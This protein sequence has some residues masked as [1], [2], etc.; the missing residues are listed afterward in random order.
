MKYLNKKI[1]LFNLLF[2]FLIIIINF[3]SLTEN[4]INY[5]TFKT[6]NYQFKDLLSVSITVLTI[7]LGFMA[8]IA[9]VL[10]SMCDKRIMK[11]ISKFDKMETVAKSIKKSIKYG[12]LCLV[13]LGLMYTNLDG[14]ISYLITSVL[15]DNINHNLE[16]L[17]Y[18][19][20]IFSPTGIRIITLYIT[21]IFLVI[22][23]DA[24]SYLVFLI[25][26]IAEETFSNT[27]V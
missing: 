8:T 23:I 7:F 20:I 6:N 21:I 22:F 27:N 26:E 25:K 14:I 1:I 18:I 5:I 24:S 13:L 2:I 9:T 15:P 17:N 4:I 16:L 3:L 10:M 12:L 19:K 11:L